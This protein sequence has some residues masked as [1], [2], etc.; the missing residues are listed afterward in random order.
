MY[1]QCT[2]THVL[3]I[4][5]L[6]RFVSSDKHSGVVDVIIGIGRTE[7]SK[8]THVNNDLVH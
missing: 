1:V 6:I 8:H 2:Y 7:K 5:R 4:V 3:T